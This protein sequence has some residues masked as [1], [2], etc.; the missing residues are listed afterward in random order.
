MNLQKKER[1]MKTPV[2]RYG[3]AF[4]TITGVTYGT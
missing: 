4:N 3:I 2:K 1:G